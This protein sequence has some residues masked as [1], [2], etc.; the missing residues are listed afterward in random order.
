M[1]VNEYV[2]AKELDKGV[3]TLRNL[4]SQRR[5][6]PY[7]KIGKSV[8][9][10]IEDLKEFIHNHTIRPEANGRKKAGNR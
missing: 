4:R 3:Q 7:V 2:A 10:N 1:L 8:R 5:G 6:P 9:Y